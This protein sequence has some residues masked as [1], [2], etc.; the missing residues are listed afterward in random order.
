MTANFE[1]YRTVLFVDD[2]LSC[3]TLFMRNFPNI[4]WHWLP[5]VYRLDDF[6]SNFVMTGQDIHTVVLDFMGTSINGEPWKYLPVRL[7]KETNVILCSEVAF[8]KDVP[9]FFLEK[10]ELKKWFQVHVDV[11]AP[12]YETQASIS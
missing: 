5:D 3:V 2:N 9:V 1:K 12:G 11:N 6:L 8:P 7:L 10:R 4:R